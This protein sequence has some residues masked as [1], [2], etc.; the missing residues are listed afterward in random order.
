MYFVSTLTHLVQIGYGLVSIIY[1][2][3][4]KQ[5]KREAANNSSALTQQFTH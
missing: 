2:I 5:G 3:V 1:E 4:N